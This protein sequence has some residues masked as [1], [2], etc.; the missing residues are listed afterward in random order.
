MVVV[1]V[2]TIHVDRKWETG[3]SQANG[4]VLVTLPRLRSTSRSLGLWALD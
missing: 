2:D 3:K 4:D 1:R